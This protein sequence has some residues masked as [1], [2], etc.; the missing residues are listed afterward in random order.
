MKVL[1]GYRAFEIAVCQNTK[2]K[3]E[4][5]D[6]YVC[7]LFHVK[8][9]RSQTINDF[10]VLFITW[11]MFLYNVFVGNGDFEASEVLSLTMLINF[12][13]IFIAAKYAKTVN[14]VF[15]G[16]ELPTLKRNKNTWSRDRRIRVLDILTPPD[17]IKPR[18]PSWIS[19]HLS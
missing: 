14:Q 13:E 16:K 7:L 6:L 5:F 12:L 2:K 18:P 9:A 15:Q 10:N 8:A 11:N 19:R 4:Q 17:L 3:K 1:N